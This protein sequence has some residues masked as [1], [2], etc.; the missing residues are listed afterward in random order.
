MTVQNR[1]PELQHHL[2]KLWYYGCGA[3]DWTFPF[4]PSH[5]RTTNVQLS[6]EVAALR[7]LSYSPSPLP[8]LSRIHSELVALSS[9][10]SLEVEA[11]SRA[12]DVAQQHSD[13]LAYN[14]LSSS[15]S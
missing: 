14:L 15:P 10:L 7:T 13:S 12:V 5:P 9:R 6:K 3:C 11:L 1:S 2:Y 8:H 4:V